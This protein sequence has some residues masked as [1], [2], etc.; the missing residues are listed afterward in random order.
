MKRYR[1]SSNPDMFLSEAGLSHVKSFFGQVTSEFSDKPPEEYKA[2]IFYIEERYDT[3]SLG[4]PDATA[5]Q[6]EW[7]IFAKKVEAK[8]DTCP[9]FKPEVSAAVDL[10]DRTPWINKVT[11]DGFDI[12]L[13]LSTFQEK[14]AELGDVLIDDVDGMLVLKPLPD[15]EVRAR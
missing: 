15:A 11:V 13:Y 8:L 1:L 5:T 4:S 6:E 2:I 3:T 7:D 14:L 12:D 10:L 9:R